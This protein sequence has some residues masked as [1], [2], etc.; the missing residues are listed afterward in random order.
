MEIDG[1]N[2]RT[3]DKKDIAKTDVAAA[4][5]PGVE[6]DI[7]ALAQDAQITMQFDVALAADATI[8]YHYVKG[9]LE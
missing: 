2:Y 8:Y 9:I 6:I 3:V 5:E 1:A 4:E 7:P